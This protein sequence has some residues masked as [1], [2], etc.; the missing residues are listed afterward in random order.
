MPG[1]A[2]V[3]GFCGFFLFVTP[4]RA[5]PL[6]TATEKA[7]RLLQTITTQIK[8]ARATLAAQSPDP[9][10]AALAA[11]E[12]QVHIA[13]VHSCHALYAAH[14]QA[15]KTAAIQ[16][17]Q[18][19][20]LQYLLKAHETLEA[21]AEPAPVSETPNDQEDPVFESALVHG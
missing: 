20:V 5:D 9:A 18:Q 6:L 4:S 15:A 2:A 10:V 21:C 19:D 13:F 14:L 1:R 8:E 11:A 7:Y 17:H 3:I 12:E 16:H